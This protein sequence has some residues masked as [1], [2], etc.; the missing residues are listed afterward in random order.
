MGAALWR[1]NHQT[2]TIIVVT[3]HG[4]E[5]SVPDWDTD[6]LGRLGNATPSYNILVLVRSW[7]GAE[8]ESAAFNPLNTTQ[9]MDGDS[10]YNYNAEGK[11]LVR[12]YISYEQGMLATV[13]TITNGSYPHILHGLITN[14][15]E[16]ALNDAEL[17]TWGTGS[18]SV[19][20]LYNGAISTQ[21]GSEDVPSG[22]NGQHYVAP[23]LQV[24]GTGCLDPN[25]TSAYSHSPGLRK[26]VIRPGE[27]WS[28]NDHW[29]IADDLVACAGQ[30]FT[31]GGVCNQASRYSN[32]A[33]ALGLSVSSQYHGYVYDSAV[34]QED[35]IAIM[36][37]GHRG[38]QD[39]V[40]TNTT[41]RTVVIQSILQDG[42]L[43]V[44]GDFE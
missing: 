33:H 23:V 24:A 19:R 12:N 28:F 27:D 34:P 41:P 35:N 30:L 36:S 29:I 8:G 3:P 22:H 6:F 10:C 9:P 39:L 13:K 15:V 5:A 31:G 2:T 43:T 44:S 25:V 37:D 16:E 40:I 18:G 4:G 21:S 26:V 20:R 32:V 14:D 11:C 1:H 7:R 17:G 38:G 42:I